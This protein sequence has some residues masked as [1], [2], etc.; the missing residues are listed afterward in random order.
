MLCSYTKLRPGDLRNLKESD[1][2]IEFGV[3]TIWRPTKT[4]KMKKPK[5]IRERLLD[6]HL[7]EIKQ[8]KQKYPASPA[9]LFFR[10]NEKSQAEIDL[11]FGIN[12]LYKQWKKVCKQFGIEDLD[13]YGATRHSSTTAIAMVA[14]KKQ[15]RN[16]SGH[17]T[18]K[19]FDRYCQIAD[20]DSFDMTK[21]MAKMRGKIIDFK[22]VKGEEK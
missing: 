16:F 17:E 6:Y 7:E 21:L 4:K 8:L 2:D 20:D 5:V 9:T 3:M 14:G 10:H 22:T 15:A 1:I 19:A 12:F 13:L 18:N 11:P